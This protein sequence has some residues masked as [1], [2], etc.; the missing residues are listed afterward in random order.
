MIQNHVFCRISTFCFVMTGLLKNVEL[1]N[2]HAFR[3]ATIVDDSALLLSQLR[4]R[5]IS[6][7]AKLI[8]YQKDS[9]PNKWE[10]FVFLGDR[11]IVK[12]GRSRE[13]L[14]A[15]SHP[16]VSRVHAT[17]VY[18]AKKRCH[19]ILDGALPCQRSRNGICVNGEKILSHELNNGDRIAIAD[20]LILYEVVQNDDLS[21]GQTPTIV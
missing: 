19:R 2:S 8:I 20:Y 1:A 3:S 14:I 21:D 6:K 7:Q 15:L 17:I 13:C 18:S 11:E 4:M 16:G 10:D 5:S 9:F 12:L